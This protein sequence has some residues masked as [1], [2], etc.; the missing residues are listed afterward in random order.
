MLHRAHLGED[1]AFPVCTGVLPCAVCFC[2][3]L[4]CNAPCSADLCLVWKGCNLSLIWRCELM[5]QGELHYFI[6]DPTN[7]TPSP[8]SLPLSCFLSR[9]SIYAPS[10]LS[11]SLIF[12]DSPPFSALVV[13]CHK[14]PSFLSLLFHGFGHLSCVCVAFPSELIPL[15]LFLSSFTCT[16]LNRRFIALHN[17]G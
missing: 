7:P 14:F 8:L 12:L 11:F 9:Y 4:R 15:F 3:S 6:L 10:S 17:T 1:D 13:H 2:L 5:P 16:S